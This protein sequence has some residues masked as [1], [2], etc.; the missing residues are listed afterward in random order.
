[1]NKNERNKTILAN[2]DKVA[3]VKE[4]LEKILIGLQ[5][6]KIP[7]EKNI[8]DL[9]HSFGEYRAE[10]TRLRKTAQIGIQ[11]SE[12]VLEMRKVSFTD[13]FST[14]K[15]PS[16]PRSIPPHPENKDITFLG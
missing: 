16:K 15:P 6:G 7:E 3:I 5:E 12:P 1:M 13:V 4:Q 8:Q 2:D 11:E 9:K 14:L 10:C